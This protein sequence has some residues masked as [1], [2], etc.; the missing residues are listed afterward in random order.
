MN[1]KRISIVVALL[2]MLL[3]LP[4]QN[5]TSFFVDNGDVD[6]NWSCWGG[7]PAH[8]FS[9]SDEC[10]PDIKNMELLWEKNYKE[11]I[12]QHFFSNDYLYL[13]SINNLRCVDAK[14]GELKWIK[15]DA[16][17]KLVIIMRLDYF[18]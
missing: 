18:R 4:I 14:N 16:E 10:A 3:V 1:R 15:E 2:S 5:S 13:V 17:Y 12:G 8:T 6:C 7:N 9:V 11:Q